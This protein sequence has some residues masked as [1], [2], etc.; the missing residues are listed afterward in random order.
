MG[1]LQNSSGTIITENDDDGP[2]DNFRIIYTVD[3]GT[4]YLKV[5]FFRPEY[6][7]YT[8]NSTFEP[9]QQIADAGETRETATLLALGTPYREVIHHSDDV[10]YFQIVVAQS[11][12]LT[13]WDNR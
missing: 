8:V 1:E 6:P 5:T 3:P 2:V 12:R 9:G 11:G 13:V 7:I 4:Y 10:D